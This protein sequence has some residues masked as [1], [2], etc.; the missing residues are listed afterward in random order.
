MC[1]ERTPYPVTGLTPAAGRPGIWTAGP[2]DGLPLVLVHGIR[3]SARMWDPHTRRLTPRFRITAPDLPG[4]GT[5]RDSTFVLEEAVA[6]VDEAVRE[7]AL[8]TGRPPLVAGASLGGYVALAYAAAHPDT[9]AAVL[10]QGAT[11]RPDRF[12]GHLYRAAARTVTA[13]GPARAARLGDRAIARRLPPESYA[14][15]TGG[16]LTLHAFPEV[17]ADL[18]RRDFLTLA[19]RC[20]LPVLFVN[21]RRD[22]LFRA[23]EKEFV[24]AVRSA[25]GYARLFHVQG[26][27]DMSI[28]DPDAFTRILER[29]H[30]LLSTARPEAFAAR[31][32]PTP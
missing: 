10:V 3:V 21:G 27:H 12:T 23:Q 13:L 6:R 4:H 22:H 16:G 5:R 19:G 9:A 8:A 15:V 29:G 30:E 7:A 20:R 31:P 18:T 11:A 32:G 1:A 24:T 26:P 14:A 28:S 17:V 25:G 2:A